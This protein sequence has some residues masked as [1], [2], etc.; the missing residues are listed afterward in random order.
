[1]GRAMS[2]SVLSQSISEILGT[3]EPAG[4]TATRPGILRKSLI[5]SSMA[6]LTINPA[7]VNAV[8]LG[9]ISVNSHLGQPLDATVPLTLAPGESLPSNCVAPSRSTSGIGAPRNMRISTPA[10]SQPGTYNLRVTTANALHEPM[11]E[12]SLLI[13]CPG[14]PVLLRQYILMLNLAGIDNSASVQTA[15]S[16]DTLTI[17]SARNPSSSQDFSRKIFSG[18]NISD[19]KSAAPTTGLR[20]N[21]TLQQTQTVIPAGGSYRVR[22]GDS[23]SMIAA[24]IAGRAPDTTWSV[25]NLIFEMNPQ[26]FIRNNP[27]LIKLGSVIDVPG[28]AQL[29][30]LERGRSA[31]APVATARQTT[32]QPET[33]G[34]R[35]SIPAPS[36]IPAPVSTPKPVVS[37]TSPSPS[38]VTEPELQAPE[39]TPVALPDAAQ[40][41]TSK[42]AINTAI[43]TPFLDEQ[44]SPVVSED[45][46]NL[47]ADV[48][49]TPPVPVITTI[50]TQDSSSPSSPLLAILIGML[51]GLAVS[52]VMFRQ[53]F[54]A[55]ARNLLARRR[56]ADASNQARK[57]HTIPATSED[58]FSST[59][60]D[61]V[62]NDT[63]IESPA[64]APQEESNLFSTAESLPIGNPAE[65]TYI[66]ETSDMDST[67]EVKAA[68][69][70]EIA[71]SGLAAGTL[72]NIGEPRR[73]PDDELLAQLFDENS[74]VV[75]ESDI[76]DPT[77]QIPLGELD[78]PLDPTVELSAESDGIFDSSPT[79]TLNSSVEQMHAEELFPTGDD[80]G[81][82]FLDAAPTTKIT[83]ETAYESELDSLPLGDEDDLSDALNEAMSLLERDFEDEFTSSQ[84]IE[85]SQ[86]ARSLDNVETD[87]DD[88]GTT[89]EQK[90]S[91]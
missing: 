50:A 59:A 19:Q 17:P 80:L 38:F 26:A 53:N 13:D 46:T 24:R 65:S 63:G 4:S 42:L 12:I 28:A 27:D 56:V 11:Y 32:V 14:T 64:E 91:G 78:L 83:N 3:A 40:L 47:M 29:A 1:M 34:E 15:F 6:L 16:D 84:I 74:S 18:Q 45:V 71:N 90:V 9:E 68:V 22:R 67:A 82:D 69:L 52:L 55:A 31:L 2:Q 30:G 86:I 87:D 60:V 57:V 70:A 66:V 25:A 41:D 33:I 77:A 58:E 35:R 5:Y 61:R 23:L 37:N 89:L 62:F 39:V 20:V 44:P 75:D 81:G 85:R 51:L 72:E 21:H 73:S 49:D 8:G 88:G 48:A 43:T 79:N 10:A 7:Q 76:F 36:P 54:L